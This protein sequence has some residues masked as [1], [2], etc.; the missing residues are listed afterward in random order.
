MS[1]VSL[2][3]VPRPPAKDVPSA[4]TG[5]QLRATRPLLSV[6]VPVYNQGGT[7][8]HN[9]RTIRER[10]ERE[11]DGPL[12]LI[13][14]SD[15]SIDRSEEF[16]IEEASDVARVIHYDR[17][18][19]KGFAVKAGA[20]AAAGQ[21]IS[22]VDSDLDLDPAAIPGY[23]E[24]ARRE[25]LDFVI[26]SK[27]HPDSLVHYPAAR[28]LSSWLYQQLVRVLF[29]LD[30]RDT[31]VGLKVF[32]REVAEEVM[33]LLLVKQ[34]AFD[35][36]LLAVA[37]SLG[38]DRLR[39]MPITLRYRFTGS[40]VRSIAVFLALVDTAAIFY[41]LRIL[42]YYGRKQALLEGAARRYAE[43]RPR[44]ALITTDKEF[45][46]RLDYPNL[47]IVRLD[48]SSTAGRRAAAERTDCEVLAF[49]GPG[50]VAA[51]NW[52]DSTLPFLGRAEVAA[53]VVPTMTPAEGSARERAA[54]AVWESRLGG[55][56]LHFRFTPGN[57]R[58]VTMFPAQ[59][60]V[61][62][63]DDYLALDSHET[64]EHQLVG[65]LTAHGKR[66]VYTPDTVVVRREPPLF[67]AH[68]AK[69]AEFGRGR[70][71]DVRHGG[72]RALRPLTLAPLA[73]LTFA[74]VSV[75]LASSGPTGRR[76]SATGWALYG[77]AVTFGA[78][79]AGLRFRSVRVG[80]LTAAG[81]V[82]THFTYG[83]S[84]LVGYLRTNRPRP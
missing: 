71:R 38:F 18:L 15:G 62:R 39:E 83:A 22:Y 14:V 45:A 46:A 30:V 50:A 17:N 6:V 49:L 82:A 5:E 11:I 70:G 60:V 19:G 31:Q 29:R 37:R 27:R 78:T 54:G 58:F 41:R 28:R 25:G 55:G 72:P 10:V 8:V 4:A 42:R 2:P 69:A 75:P 48:D 7:I 47:E 12:E 23:V 13:V 9:V 35:L 44:V 65:S 66:V 61:V 16:L 43:H 32:R 52:L 1:G 51:G 56:S 59:T 20:L 64:S 26:G 34:Y 53:V 74:A 63:R 68:L 77:A 67:G 24:T 3:R 84:F 33:P 21:Y 57:L 80:A 36:E 79:S 40:G 81:S 76:L 73:L